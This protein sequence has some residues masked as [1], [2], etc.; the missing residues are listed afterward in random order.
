M[1]KEKEDITTDS[2]EIQRLLMSDFK[3][4]YS[5][6]LENLKERD[7]FFDMCPLPKLNQD[8]INILKEIPKEREAVSKS[9]SPLKK[10]RAQTDLKHKYV[11]LSKK[12]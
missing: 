2:E 5:I 12:N 1:R 4:L 3:I 10:K 6:Q 11:R 9:H 7:K 8:G